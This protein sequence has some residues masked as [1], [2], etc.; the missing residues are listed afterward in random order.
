MYNNAKKSLDVLCLIFILGKSKKKLN[1]ENKWF[2][3]LNNRR[4]NYEKT[5]KLEHKNK[6]MRGEG[7]K[8]QYL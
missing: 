4:K 5:P 2:I 1:V 8:W 3:F 6:D 7:I